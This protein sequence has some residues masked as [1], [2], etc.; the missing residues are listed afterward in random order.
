MSWGLKTQRTL[1]DPANTLVGPGVD[2]QAQKQ[3]A[4]L[5]TITTVSPFSM[6]VF[7]SISPLPSCQHTCGGICCG[8]LH[9]SPIACA[10]KVWH[11]F[12]VICA[13]P[14]ACLK[15]QGFAGIQG[16]THS[17]WNIFSQNDWF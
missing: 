5:S 14:C 7:S 6:Q 4:R 17:F 8:A 16:G 10:G 12:S 11:G 3:R 15:L 13:L 2:L 9:I 1:A